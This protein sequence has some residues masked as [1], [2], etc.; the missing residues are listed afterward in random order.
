MST[1]KP[2]S[3]ERD[4]ALER[5]AQTGR[6]M[7]DAIVLFHARAAEAFSMGSS[8]WK[9]LGLIAQHGPI[10]HRELVRHLGLKP[11]SVTNILDRLQSAGWVERK[12]SSEDGRSIEITANE[13]RLGSFRRQ[14]FGPLMT[15]LNEVYGQYTDAELTLLADAFAR[16]ADA[17]NKAVE[18]IRPDGIR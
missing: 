9:A 7:S 16:I 14:V 5:L 12:R 15:R 4:K 8:D 11:A 17:Q 3:L 10:S 18:D 6:A 2:N 13:E 1:S